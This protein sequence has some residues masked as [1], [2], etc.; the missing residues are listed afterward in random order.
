ME[1][2]R[3]LIR[4]PVSTAAT[5]RLPSQYRAPGNQL[6][7]GRVRGLQP[8][9]VPSAGSSLQ[10]PEELPGIAGVDRSA[11]R[12]RGAAPKGPGHEPSTGGGGP[13]TRSAPGATSAPPGR[14][15]PRLARLA[16]WACGGPMPSAAA[17]ARNAG[18][19]EWSH[20]NEPNI[21]LHISSLLVSH[22]PTVGRKWSFF[23]TRAN[24]RTLMLALTGSRPCATQSCSCLQGG[25]CR[26]G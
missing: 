19:L 16:Q 10:G 1:L 25:V 11:A 15:P 9:P 22:I 17:H 4:S 12:D 24:S 6:S 18:S 23:T 8:F 20:I 5:A 3:R 26:D 21:A 2:H 13:L 14:L 7:G